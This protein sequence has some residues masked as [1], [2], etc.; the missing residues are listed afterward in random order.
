M[1]YDFCIRS[2]HVNMA[3]EIVEELAR[4][5]ETRHSSFFPLKLPSITLNVAIGLLLTPRSQAA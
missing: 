1:S 4:L 5:F 3:R 2:E